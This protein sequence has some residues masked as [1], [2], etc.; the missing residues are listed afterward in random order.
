MK[1]AVWV[2]GLAVLCL[3]WALPAAAEDCA[4]PIKEIV[5]ETPA[6]CTEPGERVL[7][8][9][10]CGETLTEE[11]TPLGHEYAETR[12]EPTCAEPG[13]V[14]YVCSRCG[15]TY[16]EDLPALGHDYE[17]T[18]LE[19]T[20][21]QPG[22]M[23]YVCANCG[24]TY[25]EDL[26]ALGHDYAETREEPTCADPGSVT[27]ICARC[28]DT[29]TEEIPALGHDY[30]ETRVEPTCAEPGSVTYTCARCG[31]TYTD[32]LAALGHDYK[33]T[34][35]SATCTK[36]GKITYTCRRCSDTY[37]KS[38]PALGHDF[39]E[40]RTEPTCTKAGKVVT[41]CTRC[42]VKTTETLPALGHEY[43]GWTVTV[44]ATYRA[45][46]EEARFCVRGDDKIT[47]AIPQ[48]THLAANLCKTG[49]ANMDGKL[50]TMDARLILRIAIGI[51][52]GLDDAQHK[53][54]DYDGKNGVTTADARYAL[55]KSIGLDP[56]APTL[57][58][59]YA[60]A[61]YTKKGY[62]IAK[63]NGMTYIVNPYGY[64][65][66][67]NKTY[68]LPA[69]YAPGDLIPECR[70]A[71]NEMKSAAARDGVNLFI[72]SGYRSYATQASLYSRYA[73]QDGYAAADTY[74][75][76]PGHSEHQTGLAMDLNSLS[77]SFAYTREGRW[78]AA[79]AHKYGF[80]I[81]YQQ[82]KQSITGYIYE[83]W[84]VRYLGKGLAAAVYNSGL[85]L[86]EYF[87]ITSV[88]Q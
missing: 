86:E 3:L 69:A 30:A 19:P 82:N 80:I 18:R 21:A 65:L 57:Q 59:G 81:R 13:S 67:A 55:R 56:F 46:G 15:D 70:A 63:K 23:I 29:Y 77:G 16:A 54:A 74:S 71:F 38:V 48:L 11:I 84:H 79:N 9:A 25:A 75:A 78:L 26:P 45:P 20:C 53:K 43:G 35:V 60:F 41:A 37:T 66:I 85:C 42:S 39:K 68:A 32:A 76:R 27:Y 6:T 36:A 34:S 1:K 2:I 22:S 47:R 73:A 50:N 49:D 87:G 31:D 83:P 10:V 33:E 52:D 5:S 72:V 24:D 8:C 51:D 4:H 88:Y 61:G 17:A 14:I 62:A 58:S 28:G 64:T 44:K 12:L 40:T 7:L